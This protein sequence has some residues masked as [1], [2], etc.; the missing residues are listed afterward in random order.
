MR[1]SSSYFLGCQAITQREVAL[2]FR[3]LSALKHAYMSKH[4]QN[5]MFQMDSLRFMCQMPPTKCILLFITLNYTVFCPRLQNILRTTR[6][7]QQLFA[8]AIALDW[9]QYQG[10]GN[11]QPRIC[12]GS[13]GPWQMRFKLH[14]LPHFATSDICMFSQLSSAAAAFQDSAVKPPGQ[15]L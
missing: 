14:N 13:W 10:E 12:L 9:W 7:H 2:D 5:V 1:S 8:V 15:S 3:L 11:L 4:V 6:Y